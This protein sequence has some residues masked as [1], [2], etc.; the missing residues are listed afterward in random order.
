[1]RKDIFLPALAVAGGGAGFVL[2]WRQVATALDQTTML[3]RR[4]APATLALLALLAVLAVA[5]L[6]L[7]RGGKS[8]ENYEQAF[9]CPS[10][11]YMTVV[12]AAGFLML[13]AAAL[14][15][16]EAFGQFS[17]WRMGAGGSFPVMLV[18]TAVLCVPGGVAVLV[19]GKGNYRGELS[20]AYPLLATLPAYGVLPWAVALYQANSRQPELM[21]FAIQILGVVCT[22]LALYAG[23]SFAFGRPRPKMC[24]FFSLMGV[25]LLLTSL[26][27]RPGRFYAVMSLGCVLLLL[28]QSYALLRSAF[29]PAWPERA[30]G[31]TEAPGEHREEDQG[32]SAL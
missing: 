7:V 19:L 8:I 18:L 10:S 21:L 5:L 20:Q 30:E 11:G 15:L 14:G 6:L 27:D 2:R 31:E 12:V 16:L 17:L 26:A 25:V 9:A 4:G 22:E 29:G 32:Q 28:G 3:F 24:L 13:A 1:M 23:A